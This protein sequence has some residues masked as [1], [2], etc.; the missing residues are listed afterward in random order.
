MT[1][2]DLIEV[3]Q[4]RSPQLSPDGSQLLYALSEADWK[5]NKRVSHIWRVP[6][7]PTEPIA[8]EAVQLTN[9]EKGESSPRWSPGGQHIAFIAERGDDETEQ[10]YLLSNSGPRAAS[11]LLL[12]PI[13]ARL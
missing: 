9:G 3:P 13:Q 1:I 12:V 7:V 11:Q 4:L 6:T 5:A 8:D 2:V 10:I